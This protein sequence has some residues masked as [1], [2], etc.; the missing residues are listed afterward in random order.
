MIPNQS[1]ITA[2]VEAA[3]QSPCAKSKRG[4]VIW[5]HWERF[6]ITTTLATAFNAP[7]RPFTCT[8]STTCRG[9]C[10][11]VA[12]HAEER[13]ILRVG[14]NAAGAELLHI[15]VRDGE[16]VASGGPSCWQCSRMILEAGIA[17]VWLLHEKG[18]RR[19]LAEEFHRLTLEN[20]GMGEVL[21]G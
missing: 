4:V 13:A 14:T 2:A 18:W 7:P 5:R 19:Y 16:P 17:G 3:R 20:C 11:K 9:V 12:V 21:R 6:G 15:K 1:Y 8:G 10:N